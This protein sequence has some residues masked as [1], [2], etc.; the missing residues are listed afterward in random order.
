MDENFAIQLF[1]GKKVRAVWDAEREKYCQAMRFTSTARRCEKKFCG[2]E[3][4]LLNLRKQLK[5]NNY[6]SNTT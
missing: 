3:K 1:E 2:I 5:W 6:D 4:G